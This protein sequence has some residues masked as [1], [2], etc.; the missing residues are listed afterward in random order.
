MFACLSLNFLPSPRN[1]SFSASTF[2]SSPFLPV[3]SDAFVHGIRI[4]YITGEEAAISET[5]V[6]GRG[7]ARVLISLRKVVAWIIKTRWKHASFFRLICIRSGQGDVGKDLGTPPPLVFLRLYRWIQKY[8]ALLLSRRNVNRWER[9]FYNDEDFCDNYIFENFGNM[10][11]NR[12]WDVFWKFRNLEL[13]F[14]MV[15]IVQAL[16]TWFLKRIR[17]TNYRWG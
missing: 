2:L 4:M 14:R 9:L 3:D 5:L 10:F 17:I 16:L 7:E 8:P 15:I 11:V 12:V 6:A 13:E 1:A